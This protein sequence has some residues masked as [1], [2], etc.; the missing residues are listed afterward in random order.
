[1]FGSYDKGTGLT[2]DEQ[3][4]T[5]SSDRRP[6]FVGTRFDGAASLDARGATTPWATLQTVGDVQVR[7]GTTAITN[8]SGQ[9][10]I[11]P[12]DSTCSQTL[13]GGICIDDGAIATSGAD[14]NLRQDNAAQGVSV[15]PKLERINLFLNG[16]YEL[17]DS[18]TFFTE[19]GFYRSK[20]HAQQSPVATLASIPI[21]VPASN[22][23]NPFGPAVFANGAVNPNRVAGTNVPAAG[24]P[25]T[26]RGL[27]FSD[28]GLKNVTVTNQQ[29]RLLAGLR[30][31][32]N[33]WNWETAVSYSEAWVKDVSDNISRTKLQDYLARSTPDAYN[34]FNGGCVDTPSLGDCTVNDQATIDAIRQDLVRYTKSTLLT[35]DFRV[36]NATLFS[37]PGGD[38][39]IAA[40]VEARRETQLDDRDARIDG[41]ITFTDPTT[42]VVAGD[43]ADSALN[44]DTSGHR[45]VFG[46]YAELAIPLVSPDLE[47]PLVRS[48]NLQVAGRFERY[49]DFGDVA[50]PKVAGAWDVVRGI[51]FR[52][53]WAK[54][55]R[56]PNLEQ[57]NATVVTRANTRTDWA[58][59]EAD[60]RAG[61][62]TSFSQC[63]RSQST[64]ARRSGNPD[65]D[66]E[67]A[68]T[69]SFGAVL[70]PPL[71][72]GLG[73]LTFTA[74]WW[75]VKQT[76][77]V[78]IFG[79]GNALTLDYLLRQTGQTNPNVIR[80]AP[81]A[82]DIADF[83]GTGLAP[84]GQ[85]LFVLDQYVNLLPQTVKGLDFNLTYRTPETGIGRFNM[86]VNA[87]H[88]L[89]FYQAPS[90]GIAALLAARAAG[91]INAGTSITDGGSLLEQ[92]R[93]PKW[94]GSASLTW[95]LGHVTV[96]AFAQYTGR[97][98]DTA[99]IDA[100]GV[101]WETK[102]RTT[103]N[104]YGQYSFSTGPLEG[105][106]IRLGV[107]N[108]TNKAP[109]LDSSGYNGELYSP[110]RRYWYANVRHS[111]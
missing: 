21:V 42:G 36:S 13:S 78:G 64:S 101:P 75:R 37:L 54:S 84:A 97:V 102:A 43:F 91:Q 29:Y 92:N 28:F 3:Y 61:R 51:R 55:F 33:D 30:G 59:C 22:Y 109:S 23:W 12:T 111:F 107:R 80:A 72:A 8:A 71:P 108:L 10:H 87:S 53:S 35:Y 89:K 44:P 24:L 32:W 56:A 88:F 52:G 99:L 31:D 105:T 1:V 40:G 95:S 48:L 18:A 60:L 11:Q 96:S 17:S 41:T 85:V 20:T 65:L 5:A 16:K 63:T 100:A 106:S 49:S 98:Y 103:A 62:I 69:L 79:E 7:R 39:G 76:G 19:A 2:S 110:V 86:A 25:V 77:L 67:R 73:N 90:A 45:E 46:A 27:L 94:R 4:F 15:I 38:V 14:R 70:E 34:V 83:T 26:I 82:T 93:R 57:T 66:P 50:V 74:D 9:F 6:L 58:F 47:I 104:L 68:K 81:T